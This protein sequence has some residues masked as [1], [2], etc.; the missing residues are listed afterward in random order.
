MAKKSEAQIKFSADTEGFRESLSEANKS[1]TLL[2][3]ELK[4]NSTELKGNAG[5][6][7]LLS[8]RQNLLQ[9]ELEASASKVSLTEQSLQKA[10]EILGE[11]SAE[12]NKLANDV[13]RAK[14]QE[15]AI[16]NE[17]DDVTKKLEAQDESLDDVEESVKKVGDGFTITKG[18]IAD[19]IS[20]AINGAISKIGEFASYLA[21]LPGETR[22]LRQ[23][24]STLETSFSNAGFSAETAKNTWKDLY[25]V[26]GE[27]DRAVETANNISK[28]AKNQQELDKWVTIT[29]GVWGT[30][31][32]SLP[33]EGLA[34]AAN[35]TSKTGT[36]T[37]AL[38]DALNWS[39]E[40]AEM[41]S[42]YM[43]GDVVTAEDAFNVALSKCST[44]QERQQLITD[45]LTQL[46]GSAAETYRDTAGAQMEAKEAAADNISAEAELA[47]TIEPLTTKWT[48][49]KT[50]LLE[51][52][53]PAFE[54]IIDK[55]SDA[56]QWCK[57]HE[58]ELTI[59]AVAVG[60]L[61]AAV[62]LYTAAEGL[63]AFA[64]STGAA[65]EGK[66]TVAMGLHA[67]ATA[68]STAATTA[69]GAAVA[70]LTSPITIVVGAITL[71]VGAGVLL[72]KNWD[73]V[74]EK[75]G[76]F[77]DGVVGKLSDLSKGGIEK[78]NA[79]KEGASK[80]VEG[81]K[82][83]FE[84]G[85]NK[86]KGF[87]NFKF[88]WPHLTLP[89][90]S[91]S[92]AGWK[93]GDLLKG[94]IPKLS[95]KWYADGMVFTKPTVINTPYGLKGFGEAGEEAAL[96]ITTLRSYMREVLDD[97]SAGHVMG[98]EIDYDRLGNS[99]AKAMTRVDQSLVLNKREFG[100]VVREVI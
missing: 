66:A 98:F 60:G 55:V 64:V 62:G 69:F 46:Y 23:D 86:I 4:L 99:V 27:D 8:A 15:A 39:S 24:M 93:V 49:L 89:H 58:T 84:S 48:E 52:A 65:A 45:T 36:V 79:L 78:F 51:G 33:V 9:R 2:R 70:F 75:A 96:P 73:T 16:K 13:L 54:G 97:W 1:M 47:E 44:E 76:A 95:I 12:Y 83:K 71:L 30:Y 92:P 88:K 28:M 56:N 7:E 17:L 50:E 18:V 38:A 20:G 61:T 90:F 68:I 77:K 82:D 21:G 34:E 74:K 67:A 43:G 59:V 53:V 6:V 25:A 14:N 85:I 22:E 91:V 37:G 81:V 10:K 31:Q 3:N 35:E 87:F 26:F 80:V 41:F 63:K 57:E 29:T 5:D 42:Q 11:N 19:F 94:T 40:A 32:D 72:Y 100:R